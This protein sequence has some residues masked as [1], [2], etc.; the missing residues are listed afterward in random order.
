[1]STLVTKDNATATNQR[2]GYDDYTKYSIM[3]FPSWNALKEFSEKLPRT[4]SAI[5]G[6]TAFERYINEALE[7]LRKNPTLAKFSAYGL[8]GKQPRTYREAM[9][10]TEFLYKEEYAKVKERIQGLI[11]EWLQMD[12]T[13][14]TMKPKFVY[15]DKAIGEFV[16]S[17]AAMSL[18]PKL[19]YYS[20]SLKREIDSINEKIISKGK[21]MFLEDGSEVVFAFK[22]KKKTS[23]YQNIDDL[24][25]ITKK[26]KKIDG[27]IYNLF[28]SKGV[29]ADAESELIAMGYFAKTIDNKLWVRKDKD[30]D[31]SSFEFVIASGE[32]S[33][34]EANKKGLLQVKSSNKKVYL[35]KEKKPKI[36]NTIRIIVGLTAGGFTS[37]KNDFYTGVATVVVAETL[38]SLGYCVGIDVVVGG[39]RCS[40]CY[41]KLNFDNQDVH[42][43][44]FFGF[45]AKE[46]GEQMDK[47]SLLYTLA[48]PSFHNIKWISL[49][50]Y[51]FAFFGDGISKN[52]SPASTWHGISG[53][54][55]VNPIGMYYKAIDYSKGNKNLLT[56]Y[57]HKVGSGE[58]SESSNIQ[59]TTEYIR[60]II[61]DT[62]N[63]NKKALEKYQKSGYDFGLAK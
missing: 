7:N 63:I 40:G 61:L 31:G 2:G 45:T 10:R 35:Y 37:W 48:D 33:L 47:E 52:G 25:T 41:K 44:R 30:N 58:S 16:F 26:T 51:F 13:A 12:S 59:K 21:K 5:E 32:N 22:V 6:N 28:E 55:M 1:M 50:N 8:N 19:F 20:P 11:N 23:K 9:E 53:E 27:A 18:E 4:S 62:L 43:R 24:G 49:L 39:G 57:V 56:F 60:N 38:E 42:G 14:E 15:N 54:D 34:K 17:K 3:T 29:E 36:Y 46:F